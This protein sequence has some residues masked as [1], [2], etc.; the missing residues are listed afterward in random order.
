MNDPTPDAVFIKNEES[1][2]FTDGR[3]TGK[4]GWILKSEICENMK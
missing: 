3:E 1:E 2:T 4:G